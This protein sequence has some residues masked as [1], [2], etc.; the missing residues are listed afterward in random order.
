MSSLLRPDY[1]L[2]RYD[3][4]HPEALRKLGIRVLIVDIDNTLVPARSPMA[5]EPAKR[6]IRALKE[7]GVQPVVVSNNMPGRIRALS[8]QLGV[9]CFTFSLKPSSRGYK[10]ALQMYGASAREAAILGDQLLTDILG[11]SRM[12]MTTIL[13]D[14]IS[15]KEN[16][17]SRF[18][19]MAETRLWKRLAEQ[20]IIR[21]G[22]YY[23]SL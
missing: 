16:F 12:G 18:S 21:K 6:F 3:L 10:K 2:K 4:V 19:R 14:P 17:F 8:S 20:N 7:A 15:R 9:H 1:Y 23:G 22:H 13:V 11:G 5:D